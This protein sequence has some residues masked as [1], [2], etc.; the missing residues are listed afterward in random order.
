MRVIVCMAISVFLTSP[1]FCSDF[2][3]QKE[4]NAQYTYLDVV[5]RKALQDFFY[6][7]GVKRGDAWVISVSGVN[8]NPLKSQSKCKA[9]FKGR[10][11]GPNHLIAE[12]QGKASGKFEIRREG[13]YV[14]VKSLADRI[15]L[16]EGLYLISQVAD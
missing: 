2:T 7:D 10:T 1:A 5:S 6:V 12:E 13:E 15:C 14:R 3:K 16:K 11:I 8:S 4:F 9:N